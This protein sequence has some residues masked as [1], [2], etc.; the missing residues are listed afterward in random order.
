[1]ENRE[2][3]VLQDFFRSLFSYSLRF[4][5]ALVHRGVAIGC[6]GVDM[7]TPLLP[8]ALPE[9]RANLGDGT[10]HVWNLTRQFAKSENE[11]NFLLPVGI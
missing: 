5:Y 11:A 6:P 8:D 1:M 7:F 9:I 4:I 2:C 3:H 10:G